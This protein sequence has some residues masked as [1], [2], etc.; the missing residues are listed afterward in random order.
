MNTN[1]QEAKEHYYRFKGLIYSRKF[2]RVGAGLSVNGKL[3]IHGSGKIIAGRN[4]NLRSVV[5]PI[6]LYADRHASIIIGDNVLINEGIISAQN[7]IEI[8]DESIIAGAI[9]YDP[10]WHGIDNCPT[11][12]APVHIGKHV[13]IGSR[14]I[15]LKGVAVG[16]NAVIGAGAV[17]TKDVEANTIVVGN[18]AVPVRK[19]SGYTNEH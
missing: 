8:G 9:I 2:H 19:T 17:V 3:K 18:P 4:L 6:E 16:D 5:S 11:K 15:I 7:L 13:W 12:T 10:D 14:A 1:I